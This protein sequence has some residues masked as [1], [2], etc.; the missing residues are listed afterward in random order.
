[1]SRHADNLSDYPIW[2]YNKLMLFLSGTWEV[3]F[4][5]SQLSICPIRL[6]SAMPYQGEAHIVVVW[7][8]LHPWLPVQW[9]IVLETFPWHIQLAPVHR[10]RL[11]QNPFEHGP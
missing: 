2:G 10:A 3:Q 9:H 4:Y 8:D 6:L 1:M 11:S 7:K 5:R